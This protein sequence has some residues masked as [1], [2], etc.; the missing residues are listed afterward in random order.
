MDGCIDG[1]IDRSIYGHKVHVDYRRSRLLF[2][3]LRAH[4][5]EIIG[6]VTAHISSQASP[7][8]G[9]SAKK[10]KKTSKF[11]KISENVRTLPNASE[12]IRTCPNASGKVRTGPNT[13]PNLRKLRKTCENF[14]KSS[15]NF[16]K[17]RD[18]ANHAT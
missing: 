4:I 3:S 14:A 15:K 12:R 1:R 9:T 10:F 5:S 13:S 6:T 16:R 2:S 11:S 8:F 17:F 18:D 7:V